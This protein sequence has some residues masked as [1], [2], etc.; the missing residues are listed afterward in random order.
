LLRGGRD[1]EEQRESRDGKAPHR[2]AKDGTEACE[3]IRH[4]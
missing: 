4:G 2:G 3:G 1:S